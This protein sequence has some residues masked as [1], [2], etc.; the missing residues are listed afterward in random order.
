MCMFGFDPLPFFNSLPETVYCYSG[1]ILTIHMQ[2]RLVHTKYPCFCFLTYVCIP[3]WVS[4][5][6]CPP[7]SPRAHTACQ[8]LGLSW[9]AWSPH[10]PRP[11]HHQCEDKTSRRKKAWDLD[12]TA[13]PSKSHSLLYS[14]ASR[15]QHGHKDHSPLLGKIIIQWQELR[16]DK[17]V[18]QDR[19]WLS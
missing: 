18:D 3:E 19:C 13:V 15:C 2:Y 11:Q 4:S 5:A 10:C 9:P 7:P 16:S 8:T 12:I 6:R 1:K 17:L 14:Q